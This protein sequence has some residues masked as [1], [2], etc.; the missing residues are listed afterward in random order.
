MNR[1]ELLA[2]STRRTHAFVLQTSVISLVI[3]IDCNFSVAFAEHA[4][5]PDYSTYSE[6]LREGTDQIRLSGS[7]GGNIN[8]RGAVLD[9]GPYPIHYWSL[10]YPQIQAE[11]EAAASAENLDDLHNAEYYWRSILSKLDRNALKGSPV[12]AMAYSRLAD[13]YILLSQ[14]D[15]VGGAVDMQ[16]LRHGAVGLNN[17]VA[18]RL[19]LGTDADRSQL[20]IPRFSD[21]LRSRWER[22]LVQLCKRSNSTKSS[23]EN[24]RYLQQA[25]DC[26]KRAVELGSA[27]RDRTGPNYGLDLIKLATL[28]GAAGDKTRKTELMNEALSFFTT[29]RR[30]ESFAQA[31]DSRFLICD[32]LLPFTAKNAPNKMDDVLAQL[33]RYFSYHLMPGIM[34]HYAREG[35]AARVSSAYK[36]YSESFKYFPLARQIK[37]NSGEEDCVRVASALIRT[38]Q[39]SDAT[40]FCKEWVEVNRGNVIATAWAKI[41]EGGLSA[42][43]GD[44]SKSKISFEA[45][46][47]L[48]DQIKPNSIESAQTLI[49]TSDQLA[50]VLS[51]QNS[52]YAETLVSSRKL[53]QRAHHQLMQIECL[54]LSQYLARAGEQL[55]RKGNFES[56]T[57]LLAAA[58]DIKQKNLGDSDEETLKQKVD[59]GRALFHSGN[60]E[61]ALA[62]VASAT[63]QLRSLPSRDDDF[64]RS[65]L[66]LYADMLSQSK[67]EEDAQKIYEELRG[68]PTPRDY[69]SN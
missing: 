4:A 21:S 5:C 7:K 17:Y 19:R 18:A 15:I 51:K 8:R 33:C 59:T 69:L 60:K 56:A 45:S 27:V 64:F 13:V 63:K 57:K 11:I 55:Q 50:T 30:T 58:S 62:Q 20:F 44:D 28:Q 39:W 53:L 37:E 1:K 49:T 43:S 41:C 52:S 23:K 47:G 25:I 66:E 65:A 2:W 34:E 22:A 6:L 48:L 26:S 68:M 38:E 12:H 29:V 16:E 46:I 3:L 61:S 24:D 40:E 14:P 36:A 54:T 9:F 35:D 31:R 10:K 32:E 67:K 42:K